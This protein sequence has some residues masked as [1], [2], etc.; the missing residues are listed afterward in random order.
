MSKQNL[1]FKCPKCGGNKLGQVQLVPT[2]FP[3]LEID[4]CGDFEYD[5]ENSK[6][7][8]G[9]V[10]TL[11]HECIDCGFVISNDYG[12]ITNLESVA[13]WVCENCPQ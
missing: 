3:I 7:A 2:I 9:D 8:G 13:K 11:T 5:I 12:P 4:R 1:K 6:D 10:E